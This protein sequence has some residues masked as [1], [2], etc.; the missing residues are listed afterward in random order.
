MPSEKSFPAFEQL[1]R[2]NRRRQD[3]E[4]IRTKGEYIVTGSKHGKTRASHHWFK[5]LIG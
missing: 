2:D 3:N 4:A 5:I 1:G